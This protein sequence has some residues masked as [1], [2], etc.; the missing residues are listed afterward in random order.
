[1]AHVQALDDE[2]QACLTEEL[3]EPVSA[4]ADTALRMLQHR[5]RAGDPGAD[6][7]LRSLDD[8]PFAAASPVLAAA[9]PPGEAPPSVAPFLELP[10]LQLHTRALDIR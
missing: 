2:L 9:P 7:G 1:M 6:E 3:L 8:A 4:D 10:P 5:S